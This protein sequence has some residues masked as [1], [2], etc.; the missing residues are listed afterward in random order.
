MPELADCEEGD[1]QVSEAERPGPLF[2]G[3]ERAVCCGQPMEPAYEL[4]GIEVY[5]C[6]HRPAHPRLYRHAALDRWAVED[7]ASELTLIDT[8]SLRARLKGGTE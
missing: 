7:A 3:D 2:K 1:E 5:R 4:W 6:R 8:E